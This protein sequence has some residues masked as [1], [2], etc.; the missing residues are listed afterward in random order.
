MGALSALGRL[1]RTGISHPARLSQA[2]ANLDSVVAAHSFADQWQFGN[3]PV[4]ETSPAP[5]PLREYFDAHQ[6][7]PG[8]LKWSH[9]FD[10]YHRH[11]Q[12]F[13]GADVY[14]IEI[15]IYS[16][17]SLDM[18]KEYFGPRLHLYGVDIAPACRGYEDERTK[19]FI[20]DQADRSFWRH[21]RTEL[22]RIDVVLDDG[23]HQHHQQIAT[24]EEL[25]PHLSPGGVYACEDIHG[26]DNG[27]GAYIGAIGQRLHALNGPT[28]FQEAVAAIHLYPYMVVIER[29]RE[30]KPGWLTCERRGTEWQPFSIVTGET[31]ER[32][33][34]HTHPRWV[35]H[36][37]PCQLKRSSLPF[38]R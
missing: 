4:E 37:S 36:W 2:V 31:D 16:G 9:Y 20:G 17:G 14:M 28:A 26:A 27:F 38:V 25:L 22:P 23:G 8:I 24:L 11:F 18:W 30:P 5:N 1:L 13:V 32:L 6:T 7:G 3:Q 29:S 19:V 10:L 34:E 15:G 33:S 12:R 21:V 35:A